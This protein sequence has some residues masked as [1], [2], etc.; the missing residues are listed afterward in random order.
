MRPCVILN[1]AAGRSRRGSDPERIRSAFSRHEINATIALTEGPGHAGE[2]VRSCGH[3][4][5][6]AVGG[7]GTLHEVVQGLDL[8][9]QRLGVI[10]AGSGN[11][12]AWQHGIPGALDA[13]V[14]R[15]AAGRERRVD[16]GAWEQGRFHNNL[17]L[18]FEAEVNRLSHEV[19]CVKGPALYFVA[20]ARALA[21]LRAWRLELRWQGGALAGEFLTCA[22][23][24]GRRVGGAFT[25]APTASTTDGTLDLVTAAAMNRRSVV[26]V[27]G[28]VLRGRD[29]GDRRIT[30]ART[31]WLEVTAP[32]AVPV[33]MDGEFVGSRRSLT[34][35]VLPGALRLL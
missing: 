10:P 7:D 20:L 11:D 29:P 34:I 3:E 15:I 24:N 35:R 28:P 31:S 9:H 14:A 18:G 26:T 27:L 8:D 1:P 21:R 25:L 30:R 2:L 12:F 23:L 22:L 19:R 4:T 17:G 5:V 6:V 13:A 16:L 33:Y 32:E